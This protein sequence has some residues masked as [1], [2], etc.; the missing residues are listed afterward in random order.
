MPLVLM[1]NPTFAI[2][3]GFIHRL[4]GEVP[5]GPFPNAPIRCVSK[6]ATVEKYCPQEGIG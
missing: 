4:S 2:S 3:E 5:F 6:F 1:A